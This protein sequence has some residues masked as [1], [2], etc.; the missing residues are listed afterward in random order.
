M[1]QRLLRLNWAGQA[2]RITFLLA[3]VMVR[4]AQEEIKAVRRLAGIIVIMGAALLLE[5][6]AAL[7]QVTASPD[8]MA[9][10]MQ[11]WPVATVLKVGAL[12]TIIFRGS[13]ANQPVICSTSSSP[14]KRVAGDTRR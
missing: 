13:P 4:R 2:S 5:G 12:I 3:G 9:T 11:A 14:S 8:A 6:R 10:K 7:A 1:L